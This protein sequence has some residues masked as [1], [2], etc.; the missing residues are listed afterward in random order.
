MLAPCKSSLLDLHIFS[1]HDRSVCDFGGRLFIPYV[2]CSALCL[3]WGP[4]LHFSESWH[5]PIMMFSIELSGFFKCQLLMVFMAIEIVEW[6]KMISLHFLACCVCSIWHY[7]NLRA[8]N[9]AKC[10]ANGKPDI[11]LYYL[12]FDLNIYPIIMLFPIEFSGL[13]KCLTLCSWL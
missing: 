9:V 8:F 5:Y 11:L 4:G 12:D 1:D 13:F 7:F 10:N 2:E 6:G 3:S